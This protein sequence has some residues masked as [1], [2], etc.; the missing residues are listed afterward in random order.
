MIT[1]LISLGSVFIVGLGIGSAL[2]WSSLRSKMVRLGLA[3]YHPKTKAWIWDGPDD[4]DG[5]WYK[6]D[7]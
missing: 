1:F 2:E 5:L 6:D 7:T 3:H 4:P